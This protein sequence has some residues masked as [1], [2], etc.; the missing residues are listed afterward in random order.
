M[1][2]EIYNN[3]NLKKAEP[4]DKRLITVVNKADLPGWHE[5]LSVNSSTNPNSNNF[6]YVGAFAY[7]SSEDNYYKIDSNLKW[8]LKNTA[9]SELGIAEVTIDENASQINLAELSTPNTTIAEVKIVKINVLGSSQ[10]PSIFVINGFPTTHKITFR[11]Q[12]GKAVKFMCTNYNTA[13]P[14]QIILENGFDLIL[15]GRSN[16]ADELLTLENQNGKLCQ[17]ECVQFMTKSEWLTDIFSV[18]V[19]NNLNSTDTDKA[20]SA[21]QG[22]ILDAKFLTKQDK[23]TIGPGISNTGD[24]LSAIPPNWIKLMPITTASTEAQFEALLLASSLSVD[25]VN[26]RYLNNNVIYDN[27]QEIPLTYP[28]GIWILPPGKS[29]T[30]ILNW[31]QLSPPPP[32]KLCAAQ[33]K[34]VGGVNPDFTGA[35]NFLKFKTPQGNTTEL[36]I[37]FNGTTSGTTPTANNFTINR[38]GLY[39]VSVK[40]IFQAFQ[41]SYNHYVALLK[42]LTFRLIAT[43]G[44]TSTT[45]ISGTTKDNWRPTY[46]NWHD[47]PIS[48]SIVRNITDDNFAVTHTCVLTALVDVDATNN[49]QNGFSIAIVAANYLSDVEIGIED[50]GEKEVSSQLIIK[51]IN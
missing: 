13:L 49:I 50:D 28:W 29:N 8:V 2:T 46:E 48:S 34:L 45:N 25:N 18:N 37:T 47:S 14:G 30:N 23:F 31:I 4:L 32:A 5:T 10:I 51:Q 39:E 44:L 12:A 43:N 36:G 26:Y 1:S 40:I 33:I 19:I 38:S 11:V 27:G 35:L 9:E 22:K 17:Y 20:L 7:V 42:R 16:G 6:L 15:N 41:S 24:V 21:N 3:F